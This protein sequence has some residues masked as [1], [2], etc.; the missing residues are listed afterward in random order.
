[1]NADIIGLLRKRITQLFLGTTM[2]MTACSQPPQNE[3]VELAPEPKKDSIVEVKIL[4]PSFVETHHLVDVQSLNKNIKIDLKYSTP[5][6]FMKKVLYDSIQCAYLQEAVA[7]R[8]ARCQEYLTELDSSLHLLIYDAVRPRSVQW[9][10]WNALD[11]IPFSQRIKFVSNPKNAS[12]HNLACAVDVTICNDDG[13][14]LD[15]GAGYDDMRQVAYPSMERHFVNV[16]ELKP[17]QLHNRQ[18]LRKVMRSPKVLQYSN[19]MVAF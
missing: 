1:M 17:G 10:M 3:V 15:M 7:K 5:D 8:L 12:L 19:R 13:D 4:V 6:N 16:G 18:L 11:T 9:D 2:L 14:V